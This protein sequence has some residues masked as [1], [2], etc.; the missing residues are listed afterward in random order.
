M[1]RTVTTSLLL[2]LLLVPVSVAAQTVALGPRL[3]FV[4]GD[5]AT[6][7][8]SS[9]L[10]GG[11]LRMRSSSFTALELSMDYRTTRNEEGTERVRETPMQASLLVMPIRSMLA[12]YGIA[13][14]G[15]YSRKIDVIGPDDVVTDS[16]LTRRIGWHAGFG[17]ELRLGRHAAIYADYRYQFVKFSKKEDE[18]STSII[19][20]LDRVAFSHQGSMWTSGFAFYF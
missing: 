13:G 16:S 7:T 6:D 17:A 1:S 3:S 11:T 15:L 2:I 18:E 9:R 10:L 14:V 4:R 19:P 8:P 5:L 12:P 20:G